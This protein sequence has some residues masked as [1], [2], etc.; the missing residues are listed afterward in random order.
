MSTSRKFRFA[1]LLLFA[2]AAVTFGC[3]QEQPGTTSRNAA[4][5]GL[6]RTVLPIA[7]T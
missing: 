5:D 1:H 4:S 2:I 6:D 3:N 7:G